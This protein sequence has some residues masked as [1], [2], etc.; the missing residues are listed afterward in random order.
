MRSDLP[1]RVSK[2]PFERRVGV[3]WSSGFGGKLGCVLGRRR[4]YADAYTTDHGLTAAS[5]STTAA[6]YKSG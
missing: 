1:G 3:Y 6:A 5:P 4:L 2:V